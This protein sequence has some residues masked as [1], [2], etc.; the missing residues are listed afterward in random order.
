MTIASHPE[1]LGELIEAARYYEERQIGLGGRFLDSV[2]DALSSLE[3]NPLIW[4]PDSQ[5][6]RKY[7]V[8]RFPYLIIYRYRDERIYIL[9]IAHAT[10]SPGYW[11][12][13]DTRE[14]S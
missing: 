8:E 13:R 12:S 6:R 3:E 1:A 9:A 11:E 4:R 2:E 5:G 10:R 7:H 14:D